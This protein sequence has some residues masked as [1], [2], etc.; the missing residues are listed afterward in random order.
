MN[1]TIKVT[2]VKNRRLKMSP[3]GI[4]TLPVSARKALRMEK[5]KGR[6]VTVAIEKDTV[7]LEPA[8][9]SGGFRVSPKGQLELQGEA[10]MA[11]NAGA[12]RHYWLE[13]NDETGK[14]SLKPYK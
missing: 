13:L 11:L 14:V 12:S 6:R 4:I 7:I 1:T 2:V 3:G 9:D 10:R 5:G 8:S